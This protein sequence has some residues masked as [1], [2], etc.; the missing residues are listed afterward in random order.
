MKTEKE[1]AVET[2]ETMRASA[3]QSQA[4]VEAYAD[5]GHAAAELMRRAAAARF[6]RARELKAP[7]PVS[8]HL[9][10]FV[11]ALAEKTVATIALL[12]DEQRAR[13]GAL[14]PVFTSAAL[15]N[16]ADVV[17]MVVGWL[18]LPPEDLARELVANVD[19]LERRF[20]S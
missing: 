6:P 16:E 11:N 8:T 13:L 20:A 5:M 9:R 3:A 10:R 7:P 17:A 19:A 4:L 1:I 15:A 18:D 14:V 2:I 12:T